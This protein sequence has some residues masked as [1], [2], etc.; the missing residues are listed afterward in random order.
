[1]SPR[2]AVTR[3]IFL[4]SAAAAG[5]VVVAGLPRPAAAA[6]VLARPVGKSG[7]T[8]PLV[9]LGT[10]ITFNVGDD[11]AGREQSAA[12]MR[13]FFAA[14]GTVIDSSPMYGSA[15]AVIGHGLAKLGRPKALYAATKVWIADG[16]AG[17]RQIEESRRLWGVDRFDLLQV[18]NLLTWHKHLE[19]L[20]AMKA[21]G[22]L[23]HIGITTSHGMR[24]GEMEKIMA[25]EPIDVAQFTYNIV[26]REAEKRLLPLAR[27]RGIAVLANRPFRQRQLIEEFEGQKLPPFAA[28][29]GC[30]SWAQFL[31]KFVISHPDVTCAIP[32]TS[33]VDHVQENLGTA[34]GPLPDPAMRRRMAEYVAAL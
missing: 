29:I 19:T 31:L 16:A 8:M 4:G 11:P 14:G 3:R 9:G 21:E 1:M 7:E 15:Q 17:P 24:H 2:K 34:T 12:V 6:P 25:S 20:K 13:A 28:E 5:A 23:R 22:R 32:A 27:E 33:R 18:H 10:W 30:T 26:D